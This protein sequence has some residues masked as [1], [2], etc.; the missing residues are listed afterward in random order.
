MGT[1]SRAGILRGSSTPWPPCTCDVGQVL[2][3]DDE[4]QV[5]HAR[6]RDVDLRGCG[7]HRRVVAHEVDLHHARPLHPTAE[8]THE[9]TAPVLPLL[10][11][12]LSPTAAWARSVPARSPSPCQRMER[13]LPCTLACLCCRGGTLDLLVSAAGRMMMWPGLP[14]GAATSSWEQQK[15]RVPVREV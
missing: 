3:A 1:S 11:S 13:G 15:E 12:F 2:V 9:S 8:A 6:L 4:P 14:S 5:V 7:L 10:P